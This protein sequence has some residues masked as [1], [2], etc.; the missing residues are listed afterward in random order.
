MIIG[1]DHVVLTVPDVERTLRF[2]AE[3][4]GKGVLREPDRQA[5]LLFGSHN[6]S[7][8]RE[9][10]TFEPK[11]LRPTPGSANFCLMTD[12]LL[13]EWRYPLAWRGVAVEA[14]R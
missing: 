8:G 1:I 9:A 4:L 11:A 2:Y 10:R 5:A 13:E 7:F 3:V 6:K 14:P 12:G